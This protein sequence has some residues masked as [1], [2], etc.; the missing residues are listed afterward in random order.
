MLSTCSCDPICDDCA[1]TV[2]HL[3]T[4][5]HT[6]VET[7]MDHVAPTSRP[8]DPDEHRPLTSPVDPA[9][10]IDVTA[11]SL[12]DEIHAAVVAIANAAGEDLE[13]SGPDLHGSRIA[14]ASRRRDETG[15]V[16]YT[17]ARVIGLRTTAT[18][19]ATRAVTS[20]LVDH[21]TNSWT[22]DRMTSARP[23][24]AD[25]QRA[26]A[27]VEGRWPARPSRAPRRQLPCP[28]CDR[29]TLHG[30]PDSTAWCTRCG[31][32]ETYTDYTARAARLALRSAS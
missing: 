5:A 23:L 21:A 31:A 30:E 24:L 9:A 17:R 27:A 11:L 1:A 19:A 10:P 22:R 28:C 12:A 20:W 16:V 15:S 29:R 26:C 2:R 25:L 13:L 8:R 18:A 14:P 32:T 4:I 6:A 3:L 7:A